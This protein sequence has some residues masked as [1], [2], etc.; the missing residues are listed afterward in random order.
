MARHKSNWPFQE[1]LVV[2][3]SFNGS[4]NYWICCPRT[5][6]S[7]AIDPSL[8]GH[9]ILAGPELLWEIE[10]VD[11][12]QHNVV[13][14]FSLLWEARSGFVRVSWPERFSFAWSL[15]SKCLDLEARKQHVVEGTSR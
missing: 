15:G 6:D 2:C 11:I 12:C 8:L 3:K 4:I 9:M 1:V 5:F 14:P 7:G 10:Y 13:F